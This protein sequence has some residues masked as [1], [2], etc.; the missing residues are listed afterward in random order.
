MRQKKTDFL[1]ETPVNKLIWKLSVP[2]MIG[3]LVYNLYNIFDTIYI[4][5][6]VGAYAAGGLAVT[7]P[8][9]IFLSAVSNTMGAGAGSIISR[10]IGK[11]DIE[12]ASRV[13]A[14]TF[15]FF[16]ICALLI[17]LFGLIFLDYLLYGMGVTE[18]LMP[19][20]KTYTRIILLG[21]V[22]STGFSS[23]IR[24]EGSSTYAMLQWVVPV[25]A[26]IILDPI[27]IFGFGMGVNGAALA[28]VISQGISLFFCLRY[29]FLS[30]KTQLSI[31]LCHF[32][33]D[34]KIIGEILSIGMPSFIQLTGRSL[35]IIL[36]NNV[37][38]SYDGDLAIS[39]YGIVN[40]I[41]TFLMIPVYGMLQG[42]QPIIGYNHGAGLKIRVR[43]TLSYASLAAGLTGIMLTF[44]LLFL[45][46]RL[47]SVFSTDS[48]FIWIGSRILKITCLGLAFSGVHMIQVSYFQ[49]VGRAF[50]SLM[51]SLCN[52]LLCFIPVLFI[53]IW[54]KGMDGVWFSFPLSGIIALGISSVCILYFQKKQNR[55]IWSKG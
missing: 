54:I 11:G 21:A 34:R 5:R 36:I 15:G 45:S 49:A 9:F 44:I 8:L 22:A 27:L 29:F 18:K 43:K 1:G 40:K 52:Y 24:A 33:P 19:Y 14:N 16:W 47:F 17:T 20:A 46:E 3:I 28:T 53:L 23:L 39:A 10:A 32:K 7:I 55:E 51:L 38:R 6:G 4:A 50:L 42:I 12:K 37:L 26:N 30:G 31:R 35:I 13:A 2:S 25:T 41:T 48:E